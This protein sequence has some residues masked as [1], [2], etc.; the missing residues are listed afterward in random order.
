M[1]RKNAIMGLLRMIDKMQQFA[2]LSVGS[3][4]RSLGIMEVTGTSRVQGILRA[5]NP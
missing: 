5:V 1:A 3:Q 4:Q 2:T